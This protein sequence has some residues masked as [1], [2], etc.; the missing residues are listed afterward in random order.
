MTSGNLLSDHP[1]L[2]EERFPD[3]EHLAARWVED[4]LVRHGAGPRLLD[5]GC[6]TGRDAAWL[7][8]RAGREVTGIDTSDAM[9]AHARSRHPGPGYHRA[10]MRDFGL[11]AVFDAIVCLDSAFLYCHTNDE[12]AAFL[13][14]C[15]AHLTPGGLLV[16]EMRN[17]AFFLGNTELLDGPRTA[18]AAWRGVTYTSRTTLHVDH[19]AQ[20]LRRRRIWT[21]D[22]GSPRT[23]Q[24]SAWRLL[25]PQELRYFLTTAGFEV[26]DLYDRPGP[27]TEPSWSEGQA[28]QRSASSDRLHLIARLEPGHSN[29]DSTS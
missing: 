2:Y 15:R 27:R 19:A 16:A 17:G 26:L 25:F 4:V 28:P 21:A 18:T 5:V 22:D 13:A 1:E 24:H 20:L 14:R 11:G 6:G 8:H 3:P 12:L 9:L 23:E 10:D 29:G 7:H